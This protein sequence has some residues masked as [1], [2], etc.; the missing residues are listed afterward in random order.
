M[1]LL[2]NAF[3]ICVTVDNSIMELLCNPFIIVIDGFNW[4]AMLFTTSL[5]C[6]LMERLYDKIQILAYTWVS[7]SKAVLIQK[8]RHTKYKKYWCIGFTFK[9]S[10]SKHFST[11]DLVL[12]LHSRNK[13]PDSCANAAPS[14]FVTSL[15]LSYYVEQRYQFIV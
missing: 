6:G 13:Q 5:L 4:I 9:A 3:L 10:S 1:Q 7:L 12:A 2:C 8:V 15:S 11:F 14:S